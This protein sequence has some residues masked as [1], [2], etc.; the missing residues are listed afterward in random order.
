M[1]STGSTSHW[2][3]E[4]EKAGFPTADGQEPDGQRGAHRIERMLPPQQVR[5]RSGGGTGTELSAGH[6]VHWP[7]VLSGTNRQET[8]P[9]GQTC[10]L[11]QTSRV[12]DVRSVR[13]AG[14]QERR[15]GSPAALRLRPGP[16]TEK[17]FS[18]PSSGA[19]ASASARRVGPGGETHRLRSTQGTC[20]HGPG[21]DT[22]QGFWKSKPVRGHWQRRSHSG[23]CYR[24]TTGSGSSP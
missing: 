3:Q 4:L 14:A 11:A 20:G 15:H 21:M 6:Q 10:V 16:T 8:C 1:L 18:A 17:G 24:D 5:Q 22:T 12:R 13:P 23:L 7:H 19:A 9:A 2:E